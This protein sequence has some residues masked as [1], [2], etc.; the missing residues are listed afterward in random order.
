VQ[1]IIALPVPLSVDTGYASRRFVQHLCWFDNH[2][3]ATH[4]HE[5]RGQSGKDSSCQHHFLGASAG[6]GSLHKTSLFLRVVAERLD[7]SY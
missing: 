6:F 2:H 7:F 3:D 4:Q 5:Q 1:T